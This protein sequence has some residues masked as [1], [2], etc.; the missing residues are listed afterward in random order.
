MLK[1]RRYFSS[2][3]L[4]ALLVSCSS[5]ITPKQAE[6]YSER[7]PA[8]KEQSIAFPATSSFD[9]KSNFGKTYVTFVKRNLKPALDKLSDKGNGG[10]GGFDNIGS[11]AYLQQSSFLDAKTL[12]GYRGTKWNRVKKVYEGGLRDDQ[13][14]AVYDSL[15]KIKSRSTVDSLTYF[16][17]EDKAWPQKNDMALAIKDAKINSAP[18]DLATL[19]ALTGGLG[20]KVKIDDNNYNYHVLYKTGKTKP[21]E[22][23]MSGRSF[24]SSPSHGASDATDPEYL[25]DLRKYLDSTNDVKPF[26]SAMI[27]AL[28]SSD[29]SGWSNLSDLGQ[30]VLSD[31]FTVYTAEL[32][33]HL[34]VNLQ[35]GNHPWEIDL[36]A[37]TFV[38]AISAK[39]G[40]VIIGGVV[41]ESDLGGWFAPSPNN[42]PDGPQRS[43][44]G[45]TR[46]DRQRLQRAIHAHEMG[47]PDGKQMIKEIQAIVGNTNY[48]ND[49]IQAVFEYLSNPNTPETM[50]PKAQALADLM[51]RFIEAASNDSDE[52]L[53]L[54]PSV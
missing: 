49:V 2:L 35:R 43:G 38:S 46:K 14:A 44:I 25:K 27:M 50:G 1:K 28:A 10:G 48:K 37:V 52:I 40:K 45:I 11:E 18:F 53:K 39:T 5:H 54:V 47:T 42:K 17:R 4:L 13:V 8:S 15:K 51:A 16:N 3:I 23:V 19:Y 9:L 7:S 6:D 20:V 32:D 21:H 12:A 26:Y 34:M 41:T 33:R 36:A 31:F 29:S 22:E 24:A 30:S